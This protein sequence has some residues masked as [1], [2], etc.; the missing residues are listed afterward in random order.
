MT[1]CG[2]DQ[3]P[4]H[5]LPFRRPH[6]RAPASGALYDNVILAAVQT[7]VNWNAAGCLRDQ[8]PTPVGKYDRVMFPNSLLLMDG[9]RTRV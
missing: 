6:R 2:N 1:I 7:E 3:I 4:S 9:E 8:I 5:K